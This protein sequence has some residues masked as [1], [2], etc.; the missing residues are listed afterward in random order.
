[1]IVPS[2]LVVVGLAITVGSLTTVTTTRYA[3]YFS[4]TMAPG[5]RTLALPA[6]GA[7]YVQINLTLGGCGL[8]VY[9]ATDAQAGAFN[10]TGALPSSWIDCAHRATTAPGDVQDLILVESGSGPMPY[11]VTVSAFSVD[12]PFGWIALPGTAVTLAGLILLVPRIVMEK[13]TR[14]RDEERK[15]WEK[16]K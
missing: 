10:A 11:N 14:M 5:N 1:M 3:T 12:T 16:W 4:G 8:R 13:A 2:I 9:P 6:A 15:K 7:Q